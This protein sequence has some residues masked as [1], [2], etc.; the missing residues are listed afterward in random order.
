MFAHK[1]RFQILS[2][3]RPVRI[4]R[5]KNGGLQSFHECLWAGRGLN[6]ALLQIVDLLQLLLD[7]RVPQVERY[8][9][10]FALRVQFT[11]R[12]REHE[13]GILLVVD[14]FERQ[15]TL[16]KFVKDRPI[17]PKQGETNAIK[18]SSFRGKVVLCHLQV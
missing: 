6:S 5:A 9:L 8:F 17:A 7:P 14:N 1:K 4:A 13:V 15:A 2:A 18:T 16:Y 12:D 10:L 3:S 11:G